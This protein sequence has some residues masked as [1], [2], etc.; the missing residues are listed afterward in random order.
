MGFF[1]EN[2]NKTWQF[3]LAMQMVP[4]CVCT[5]GLGTPLGTERAGPRVNLTA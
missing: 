5:A 1:L 4:V 2:M 3:C